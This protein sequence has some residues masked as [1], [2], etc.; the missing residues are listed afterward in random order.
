MPPEIATDRRRE[1]H[2]AKRS[3]I[4]DEAWKLARRDGLGAISLRDLAAQVDLRQPSLYAYFDSKLAL[5]DAMFAQGNRQLLAAATALPEREDPVEA[6]A[7]LV[8]TIIRFSTEDPV[9]YQLLFQRPVPGFEP[10]PESYAVAVAFYD[11]AG[12]RLAAAGASEPEDL[13]LFTAIVAGLSDQQVA[14]DP[15]GDRWVRLSRRA[16]RMYLAELERHPENIPSPS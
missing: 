12:A 13:D 10:S 1:R 15:G 5:F 3:T 9:R 7:E 16:V 2:E 6:L 4:I 8:E 14:N 11:V